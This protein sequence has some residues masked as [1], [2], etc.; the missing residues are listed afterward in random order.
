MPLILDKS[1]NLSVISLNLSFSNIFKT[2]ELKYAKRVNQLLREIFLL[3][4]GCSSPTAAHSLAP[5]HGP[6][7]L[8]YGPSA[9]YYSK[10]TGLNEWKNC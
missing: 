2:L 7:S 10:T 9:L 3:E 4:D 5:C 1:L 6:L 8:P